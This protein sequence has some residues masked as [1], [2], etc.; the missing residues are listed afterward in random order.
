LQ[1]YQDDIDY[2]QQKDTQIL[3]ISVD[4]RF[5]QKVYAQQLGVQFP[6]L[7]DFPHNKVSKLYGILDEERGV[8][9]RTTFVVDK[10]GIIRRIDS[11]RNAIDIAGV[12][13]TCGQLP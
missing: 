11:G 12:K 13:T 10:E 1:R 6:L 5:S 8:A 2:F 4:T 3:G 9:G 7:S